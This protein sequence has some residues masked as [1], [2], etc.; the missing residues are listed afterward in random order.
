MIRRPPRSTLF[1]YTTLFRSRH[2]AVRLGLLRQVVEDDQDVLALVH[3][4]LA[5]GRAGVRGE[6]LEA[7][8]VGR[9]GR[10]DRRVLERTGL[11]QRAAHGRDGGALLADGDVDAADLLVHVARA[12]VVALV[13]DRVDGQGGLARLAVADDQLTLTTA[14]RGHGVDGL[15]AGLHR[16]VDRLTGHDARGLQLEG[17]AALGRDL[18][19]T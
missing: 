10:D 11:L 9:R 14:D 17:A 16:L 2:G 18:A 8:R 3:P 12:P 6:V 13:D 1:P 4:V 19:E 5:D 7:G 15:V